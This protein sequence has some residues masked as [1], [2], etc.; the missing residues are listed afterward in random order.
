MRY[1]VMSMSFAA[2]GG[3]QPAG[4]G[5]AA[6][7]GHQP[8]D[9]KEEILVTAVVD[10]AAYLGQRNRIERFS[11]RPRI[12]WRDN[13]LLR[14]IMTRCAYSIAISGERNSTLASSKFR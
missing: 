4:D 7:A 1:I 6:G 11:Q 5:L 12:R 14:A 10:D 9:V 3:V 13:P 8:I 2:A